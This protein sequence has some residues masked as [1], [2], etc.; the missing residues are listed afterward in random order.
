MLRVSAFLIT[1]TLG[2]SL[3][4][5]ALAADTP[6]T[7]PLCST[8]TSL[9]D[10]GLPREALAVLAD[11][12]GTQCADERGA[13]RQ[14][15]EA[16]QGLAARAV[17]LAAA[18][19]P[20]WATVDDLLGRAETL[21]QGVGT[22]ATDEPTRAQID[23][24]ATSAA[25]ALGTTDPET[26]SRSWVEDTESLWSKLADPYL[27]SLGILLLVV[28]GTMALAV[29]LARLLVLLP[30]TNTWHLFR[31]STRRARAWVP[32]VGWG[33]AV[34]A[35]LYA[36]LILPDVVG[37]TSIAAW[38]VARFV[39]LVAFAAVI[40]WWSLATRM[41][42]SVSVAGKSDD[43]GASEVIT[44]LRELGAE[45]PDGI[46]IPRG[47]DVDVL[48]GKNIVDKPTGWMSTALALVQQ[49]LGFTP[50]R[51]VIDE[52]K[53][54]DETYVIISRNGRSHGSALIHGKPWG[55]SGPSVDRTKMAA[56]FVL[57]SLAE[58]YAQSDF[59]GLAGAT[60]WRSVGLQY[61]ASS[62][63]DLAP[64]KRKFLLLQAIDLDPANKLA[65][66]ALKH[67]QY[68]MAKD[69]AELA[70]YRRWLLDTAAGF[71]DLRAVQLRTRY[72]ALAVSINRDAAIAW[73]GRDAW[74][75][76]APSAETIEAAHLLKDSLSACHD[77]GLARS[78][79]AAATPL[80]VFTHV[81]LPS[82]L[83]RVP[84]TP[85]R[86]YNEVGITALQADPIDPPTR[87]AEQIEQLAQVTSLDAEIEEAWADP[88][89]TYLR[90]LPTWV[91]KLGRGPR[92][93]V[94]IEP[95][96]RYAETLGTLGL[97]TVETLRDTL[98]SDTEL[99]QALG[100]RLPACHRLQAS[101][102]LISR[103][104]TENLMPQRIDIFAALWDM[105]IHEIAEL[106]TDLRDSRTLACAIAAQV[107]KGRRPAPD[108][109]ALTEW[110]ELMRVVVSHGPATQDA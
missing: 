64:A 109:V 59:A 49:V 10:D 62:G 73:K 108:V 78:M 95:F 37:S 11:V 30:I 66:L 83:A 3:A 40:L 79:A 34:L 101:V 104:A 50:W 44:L 7:G 26:L 57:M 35:G 43:A 86:T 63:H 39:G 93:L 85:T 23:A 33:V 98:M 32:A 65:Q 76:V 55:E 92:A 6:T 20:D 15:V 21:D 99:A 82:E 53:D 9:V 61:V 12:G 58:G 24:A 52:N 48:A 87:G 36:A 22:A 97:D 106:L 13:A 67:E 14:A 84:R 19:Q 1:A 70:D 18:D 74:T 75:S 16:A 77:L 29:A 71:P 27:T 47:T 41:R 5:P 88:T 102:R 25:Q 42:I 110:I 69:P 80:L 90:K 107:E 105:G 17:D 89:F 4:S 72:T 38:S 28:L 94:E 45:G 8:A 51:V 68:R 46:E 100:I 60:S 2:L 54:D 96:V 56:A 103:L 31:R 91:E 81:W